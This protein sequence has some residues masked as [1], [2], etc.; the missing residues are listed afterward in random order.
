MVPLPAQGE[1]LGADSAPGLSGPGKVRT[2]C[3]ISAPS[4]GHTVVSAVMSGLQRAYL[5]SHVCALLER[6]L[7]ALH[8]GPPWKC[9]W[10]P[11]WNPVGPQ[12]S[13]AL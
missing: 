12:Q 13:P 4:Q 6:Q 9:Q 8:G 1:A 11:A 5:L 3:F 7:T 2:I 10:V